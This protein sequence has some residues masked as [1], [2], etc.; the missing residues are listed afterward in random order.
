MHCQEKYFA[1]FVWKIVQSLDFNS[2]GIYILVNVW[3]G[4]SFS[5]VYSRDVHLSLIKAL[6][7][8]PFVKLLSI[9]CLFASCSQSVRLLLQWQLGFRQDELWAFAEFVFPERQRHPHSV[10][11]D[12]PTGERSRE[13]E[14]NNIS[15]LEERR[16]S[17]QGKIHRGNCICLAEK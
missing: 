9:L 11:Q 6:K 16:R 15:W 3:Q 7:G 4:L 17:K 10:R 8:S 1:N 2:F 5:S 12:Q 13:R 14:R